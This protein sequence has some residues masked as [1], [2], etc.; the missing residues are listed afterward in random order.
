M[1]KKNKCN[2]KLCNAEC[3]RNIMFEIFDPD[4]KEWVELHGI[5]V[6]WVEVKEAVGTYLKPYADFNIPCIKL[7]NNKCSIHDTRPD[8]CRRFEC[9]RER[10]KK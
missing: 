4:M 5:P 2:T 7:V 8:L 1:S 3:C 9:D 6:K 10:W